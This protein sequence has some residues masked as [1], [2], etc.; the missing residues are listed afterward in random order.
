MADYRQSNLNRA[1]HG[2]AI[3]P[4]RTRFP[5]ITKFL[6]CIF[7]TIITIAIFHLL[8]LLIFNPKEIKPYVQTATLS[9]FNLSTTTTTNSTNFLTYNLTMDLTIRNPNKR[10]SLYYDYIETQALYDD[11][12]IGFKILDP[13]YQ[14]KKNTA[15]LHPQFSNRTAVLNDSVVSTYKRDKGE[16]FFYV[17]VKVYTRIRLKVWGFNISGFKPEF[18]CSL[19]LPAPTSSG[20]AVS[21]FDRT[22]CDVH[23]FYVD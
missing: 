20:S 17:N 14:G 12:R 2:P 13:F 4:S 11:S 15:V 3:P 19:K 1:Y 9:T 8:L 5:C 21:T 6:K 16:G 18:E 23:Y 10:I 7:S 22:T